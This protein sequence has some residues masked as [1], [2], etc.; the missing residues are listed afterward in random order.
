MYNVMYSMTFYN[1]SEFYPITTGPA[2]FR[3]KKTIS[4]IPLPSLPPAAPRC[5]VGDLEP[6]GFSR[7]P[8]AAAQ[9]PP[10][11]SRDGDLGDLGDLGEGRHGLAWAWRVASTI[12]LMFAGH[13]TNLML[14][15]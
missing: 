13:V 12:Q 14:F 2:L 3:K 5:A 1:Y 15:I 6:S 4:R 7:A 8:A 11:P 9:P 10:G